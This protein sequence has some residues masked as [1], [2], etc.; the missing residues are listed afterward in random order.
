MEPSRMPVQLG[1]NAPKNKVKHWR[2]SLENALKLMKNP[3][4]NKRE[5]Q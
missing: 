4:G 5:T 2:N 3:F 1:Q